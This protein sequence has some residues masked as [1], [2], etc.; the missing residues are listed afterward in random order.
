MKP[1]TKLLCD[2]EDLPELEHR[3]KTPSSFPLKIEYL[4]LSWIESRAKAFTVTIEVPIKIRFKKI[5]KRKFQGKTRANTGYLLFAY[6]T[7]V[8]SFIQW[9]LI[10]GLR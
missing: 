4:M 7:S 9:L 6:Y 8:C 2:R 10:E 3:E 1:E 5:R